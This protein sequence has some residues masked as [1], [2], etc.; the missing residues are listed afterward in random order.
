MS[1]L[2]GHMSYPTYCRDATP[3]W[4]GSA[5]LIPHFHPADASGTK[6]R[7]KADLYC[8]ELRDSHQSDCRV[9]VG[10][11]ENGRMILSCWMMAHPALSFSVSLALH[12]VLYFH[13]SLRSR[14]FFVTSSI[15]PF[16]HST[17]HSALAFHS[18]SPHLYLRPPRVLSHL[19]L[20]QP[21]I[22]MITSDS[23]T[24]HSVDPA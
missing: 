11:D 4:P 19:Q 21:K 16:A 2:Y 18:F 22:K 23:L 17:S 10:E 6:N 13:T 7:Q 20:V 9:I 24:P 8:Q 12:S 15:I 14:S 3:R 5:L 1:C